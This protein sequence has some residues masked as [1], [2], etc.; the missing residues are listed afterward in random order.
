LP[1]TSRANETS[2]LQPSPPDSRC[3]G[4]RV[5]RTRTGEP[6]I[7]YGDP[8]ENVLA[9]ARAGAEWAWRDLYRSTAGPVDRYLRARGVPDPDDVVGDTFLN[10]V[11]SIGRFDGDE[12]AFRAWVFAIARNTAIDRARWL[13]R[14]PIA[15]IPT[16]ELP[17]RG[18][19]GDVEAEAMD[20]LALDHVR[21]V[22][23][24]L[25]LDQRDVLLLRLIGGLTVDQVA[26][27]VGRKPGAVKM[28]QA[29]G[30]AAIRREIQRGAVTL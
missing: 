5:P 16:E 3:I 11:R 28:L 17:S 30:L 1:H 18:P 19:T 9:A 24:R 23:D 7:T 12:T 8:F 29:R 27:V 21:S 14:R 6:A 26:V 15:S 22:L 13:A 10:V 4:G 25:T 20:G 2:E